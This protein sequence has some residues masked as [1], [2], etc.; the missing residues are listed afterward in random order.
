[1]LSKKLPFVCALLK[2]VTSPTSGPR[3]YLREAPRGETP[4]TLELQGVEQCTFR[5]IVNVVKAA[6]K[7]DAEEKS[8]DKA[9]DKADEKPA[10]KK[11]AAKK[12]DAD[13]KAE[14]KPAKK[15]AA[16]KILADAPLEVL[17]GHDG[18]HRL[19]REEGHRTE[20]QVERVRELL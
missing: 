3:P 17:R 12:A 9:A 5:G 13:E 14:D 15:K 10:K 11:A 2:H 4:S 6:K 1:M 18:P 8:A 19:Q 7:A 16:P 20:S